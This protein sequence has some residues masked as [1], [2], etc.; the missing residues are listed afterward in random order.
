MICSTLPL[1]VGVSQRSFSIVFSGRVL[2]I[3]SLAQMIGFFSGNTFFAI[4]PALLAIGT[5]VSPTFP[6]IAQTAEVTHGS[7]FPAT[8]KPF[9][10]SGIA[11]SC[12]AVEPACW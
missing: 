10:P 6:A 1:S 3:P 12:I 11:P 7:D 8:F 4:S 9:N 5:T 2:V